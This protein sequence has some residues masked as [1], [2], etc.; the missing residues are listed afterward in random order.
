MKLHF[1]KLHNYRETV[2]L[3]FEEIQINFVRYVI[4]YNKTIII[5]SPNKLPWW[6]SGRALTSHAEDLGFIPNLNIAEWLM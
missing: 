3:N 2:K 6:I 1:N 5:Y 4:P